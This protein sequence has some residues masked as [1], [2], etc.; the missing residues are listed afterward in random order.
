MPFKRKKG[1]KP[2]GRAFKNKKEGNITAPSHARTKKKPRTIPSTT[3]QTTPEKAVL[4]SYV[5][6][7]TMNVTTEQ[8]WQ[9]LRKAIEYVFAYKLNGP[10]KEH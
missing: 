4:N 8:Q 3:T 6:V 2:I 5:S 10:D 1:V 7:P 9:T